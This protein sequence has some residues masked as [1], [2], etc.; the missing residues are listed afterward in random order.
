MDIFDALAKNFQFT[1]TEIDIS[2]KLFVNETF[3]A[4]SYFLKEEEIASK[5]A[6][7]KTGMFRTFYVNTD[8]DEI[9]TAFHEPNTLLLSLNS[10]NNQVPS[11][12]NIIAIDHS[13]V[14]TITHSNW[15]KLIEMV[16][17]WAEVRNTTSDI[18]GI[19]LQARARE[20]QTLT[21][22]E[23]YEKFCKKH[24]LVIQ[25]APLGHIASYLG[26]DIATLSRIRKKL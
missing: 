7:V 9:T 26:I 1:S 11:K 8:G 21:A 4:K 2:S 16:P 22:K 5:F 13:E 12:E 24:P 19:S 14:L 15:L 18:I 6:I 25:K 3:K 23:R 17:R 10:F 20:L